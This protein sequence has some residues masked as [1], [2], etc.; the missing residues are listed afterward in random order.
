MAIAIVSNVGT[1][2]TITGVTSGSFDSTGATLIIVTVAY[3]NGAAMTTSNL[4]DNKGNSWTQ[5]TNLGQSNGDA[6]IFYSIPSSTGS[7][8]T[9][10]V[11][12]P[13]SYPSVGVIAVS[14]SAITSP[15]DKESVAQGTSAGSVTPSE[16]N[17]ILIAG[18][19]T[20]GGSLSI[21]SSFTIINNVSYLSGNHMGLGNAY[22]I[23]TTA[24]AENPVWSGGSQPQSVI[25]TFKAS[26]AAS[27]LPPQRSI[28]INQ[29]VHHAANY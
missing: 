6:R 21:G 20:L 8:H 23:Q 4:S 9:V 29:S 13:G 26:A 3:Y 11:S 12:M 22:K 17:E 16:D 2:G 5:L 28:Q 24:G 27:G 7:G 18:V 25:A 14:G 1:G 15:F 19:V 10:T